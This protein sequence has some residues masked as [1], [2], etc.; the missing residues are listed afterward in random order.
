MKRNKV[1]APAGD[2]PDGPA[3]E[4]GELRADSGVPHVER[5]GLVA[6]GCTSGQAL[7]AII[8]LRSV[9]RCGAGRLQW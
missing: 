6:V 9:G 2:L 3:R 7:V 5:L 8:A 4:V 1:T